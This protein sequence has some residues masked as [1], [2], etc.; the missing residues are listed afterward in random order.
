MK[1][2]P[3]PEIDLARIAP[4]PTQ[5]KRLELERLKMSKPPFSYRPL[6]RSLSD[7]LNLRGSLL[8][9]SERVPW[10]TLKEVIVRTAINERERQ[11]NLSVAEGLYRYAEACG[12]TGRSH[13]FF[14]LALG[15]ERKVSYW[16]PA[17][18]NLDGR[19]LVPFFDPRQ[20][21]QLGEEARRFAFSVMHER[22]RAAD[23]DF[24]NVSLGIFQF[25]ASQNEGL[26]VPALHTDDGVSLFG[27][28]DLDAMVRETYE[29]WIEISEERVATARRAAG[30]SSGGLF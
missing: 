8:E 20:S 7:I 22:I 21:Y 5:Q 27:F 1:I 28:D 23:P 10:S 14:P 26:R 11:A 2:R 29:L 25:R 15:V 6:R 30:G 24:A 16:H 18:L 17:I 3:L 9:A 4:L 13:D 19:P 12:M